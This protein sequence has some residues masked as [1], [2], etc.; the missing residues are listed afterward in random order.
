[1]DSIPPLP[2]SSSDAMPPH[3]TG[4]L[5]SRGESPGL[6]VCIA[7]AATLG[8]VTGTTQVQ[9]R[10]VGP[11]H[12]TKTNNTVAVNESASMRPIGGR[13]LQALLQRARMYLSTM[14]ITVFDTFGTDGRWTRNSIGGVV[15]T[16]YTGWYVINTNDTVTIRPEVVGTSSIAEATRRSLSRSFC[17]FRDERGRYFIKNVGSAEFVPVGFSVSGG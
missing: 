14:P 4:P 8:I 13:G 11:M 3:L 2:Q 15:S 1:M 16:T 5:I 12:S 9:A 7:L 10:S 17:V 6:L